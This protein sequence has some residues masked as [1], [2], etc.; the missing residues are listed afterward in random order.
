M[1]T[2]RQQPDAII[3]VLYDEKDARWRVLVEHRDGCAEAVEDQDLRKAMDAA[4]ERITEH[5]R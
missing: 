1:T 5:Y 2:P 4:S 3:S